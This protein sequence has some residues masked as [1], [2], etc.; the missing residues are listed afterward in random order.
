MKNDGK[1]IV[2]RELKS[3]ETSVVGEDEHRRASF[4]KITRFS[5]ILTV[6]VSGLALFS[7]GM[8]QVLLEWY[9]GII[10]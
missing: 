9:S 2:N 4:A 6:W 1:K 7:D 3:A 8:S 5:S 10:S